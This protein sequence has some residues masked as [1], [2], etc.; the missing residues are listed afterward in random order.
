MLEAR[1]GGSRL[2]NHSAALGDALLAGAGHVLTR[3]EASGEADGLALDQVLGGGR[4]PRLPDDQVQG[5]GHQLVLTRDDLLR[6]GRP[7][8]HHPG[9][10]S[11][12][13]SRI[14]RA[15]SAVSVAASM[16]SSSLMAR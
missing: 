10:R 11:A 16:A 5:M 14:P 13:A 9:Y 12:A 1:T 7:G 2:G 8:A 4:G 6:G 3:L 15:T